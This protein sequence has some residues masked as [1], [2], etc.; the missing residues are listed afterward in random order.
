MTS[1]LLQGRTGPDVKNLQTMLNYFGKVQKPLVVDGI[2]GPKTKQAVID[3][4][5]SVNLTPDGVVGPLTS[6]ALLS[7]VFGK[8]AVGR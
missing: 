5:K 4:Q 6:K 7:A 8:L 3:F 1:Y 2:F